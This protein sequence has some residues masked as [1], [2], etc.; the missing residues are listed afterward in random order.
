MNKSSWALLALWAGVLVT[1]EL[2]VKGTPH[3]TLVI[4]I[5]AAAMLLNQAIH[6]FSCDGGWPRKRKA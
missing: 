2:L 1:T 4:T 3:S 6:V 5:L